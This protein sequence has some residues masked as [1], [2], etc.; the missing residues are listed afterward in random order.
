MMP[1]FMVESELAAG[2]LAMLPSIDLGVRVCFGAAWL[3]RRS[4]SRPGARFV[5]LLAEYDAA[6]AGL[7]ARE[8]TH[9][10]RTRSVGAQA[11]SAK[12]RPRR[13]R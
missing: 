11:G 3:R 13:K 12:R 1:R 2:R 4:M 8:P 10:K 9:A 7:D 5:E 6:L